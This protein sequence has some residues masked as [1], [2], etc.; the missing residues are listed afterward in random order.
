MKSIDLTRNVSRCVIVVLSLAQVP[1][2]IGQTQRRQCAVSVDHRPQEPVLHD[3][4]AIVLY[5]DTHHFT[6]GLSEIM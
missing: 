4:G 5:G 6:I 1:A 2:R 3:D